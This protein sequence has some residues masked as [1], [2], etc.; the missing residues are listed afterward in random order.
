[1][2]QNPSSENEAQAEA[3]KFIVVAYL[4]QNK[5][6]SKQMEKK[7][8]NNKINILLEDISNKDLS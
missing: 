6:Q 2:R 5:R 1:M 4:Q 3:F 7:K 8:D